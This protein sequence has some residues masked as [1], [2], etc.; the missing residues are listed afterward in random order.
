[1]GAPHTEFW[2]EFVV[3]RRGGLCEME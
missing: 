3:E 1:M 2:R